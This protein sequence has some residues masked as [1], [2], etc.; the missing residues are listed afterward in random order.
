MKVDP[1]DLTLCDSPF[2]N[3]LF[4]KKRFNGASHLES[5][6][7][8]LILGHWTNFRLMSKFRKRMRDKRGIGGNT[9]RRKMEGTE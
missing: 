1:Y 9:M 3:R 5:T 7:L 6:G 2:F 8:L 4:L